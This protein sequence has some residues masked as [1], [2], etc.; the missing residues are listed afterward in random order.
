M[1]LFFLE[2]IRVFLPDLESRKRSN[3]E[4]GSTI[5]QPETSGL[6]ARNAPDNLDYKSSLSFLQSQVPKRN[7]R[8][9]YS[10]NKFI[11]F[12]SIFYR[13]Y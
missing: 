9:L 12:S 10:V 8:I 7:N 13:L 11:F 5:Y 3:L 2:S 6:I 4:H 1:R